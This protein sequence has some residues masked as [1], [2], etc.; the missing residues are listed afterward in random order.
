MNTIGGILFVIKSFFNLKK[1]KHHHASPCSFLILKHTT[2][3]RNGSSLFTL[4]FVLLIIN[5]S[6]SAQPIPST[7][8]KSITTQAVSDILPTSATG[9][10]NIIDLGTPSPTA[11][12]ICWNTTGMPTI[13]DS[14]IDNG[15]AST[16]GPY[17]A[18]I[19]TLSPGTKYYARAYATNCGRTN[20]G[21]QVDFTTSESPTVTTQDVSCISTTTATSNGSIIDLGIP[22]ITEHGACW[23][24]TGTPT[25]A[26]AVANNGSPK[27]IGAFAVSIKAL[28]SGTKY[29]VRTYATN[30]ATTSYGRQVSFTTPSIPVINIGQEFNILESADDNTIIGSVLATGEDSTHNLTNWMITAGNTDGIFELNSDDGEL[31]VGNNTALDYA[32]KN[33]YSLTLTVE[34]EEN[35][36]EEQTIII[37]VLKDQTADINTTS[38][39]HLSVYPNP[40]QD[41]V[42]IEGENL[43]QSTIIDVYG[44]IIKRNMDNPIINTTHLKDG[45]YFIVIETNKGQ[46]Q[47]LRFIKE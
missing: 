17:T 4:V 1:L 31:T 5:L 42:H 40:C 27:A 39:D 23:N 43:K 13:S 16:T 30:S 18:T 38:Y 11:H 29:Y 21:E 19:N 45:M 46:K 24:T 7:P 33:T 3:K 34:N 22:R 14:L 25:I 26:D 37:K 10:G 9:N 8:G 41:I 28:K 6:S 20:Y 44:K 36:S 2:M 15:P 47:T 12:G 35:T 32:T